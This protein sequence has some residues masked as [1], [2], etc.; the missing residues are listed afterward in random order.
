MCEGLSALPPV[1]TTVTSSPSDCAALAEQGMA[2][3]TVESGEDRGL[4]ERPAKP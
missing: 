3:A 2:G 1:K 4:R